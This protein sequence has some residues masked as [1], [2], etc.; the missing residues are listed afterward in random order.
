MA[1]SLFKKA[2][3]ASHN[4]HTRER[5]KMSIANFALTLTVIIYG[6]FAPWYWYWRVRH[7]GVL[8]V[9]DKALI[10]GILALGIGALVVRV[11]AGRTE[12]RLLLC[13]ICIGV[14]TE[15]ALHLFA[16]L[17]L[18]PRLSTASPSCR[19]VKLSRSRNPLCRQARRR[20]PRER[21]LGIHGQSVCEPG[22]RH[23]L[24]GRIV[25]SFGQGDRS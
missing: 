22:I 8:T 20:P 23:V 9:P 4:C 24:G 3:A 5:M 19:T 1:K 10:V 18:I 17:G 25:R 11:K 7:L 2:A 6:I 12:T 16:A 13:V 21:P 14:M 15:I